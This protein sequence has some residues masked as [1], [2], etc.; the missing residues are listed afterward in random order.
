MLVS[1]TLPRMA[2]NSQYWPEVV[3][4]KELIGKGAIGTLLS[5]RG[6]HHGVHAIQ[7]EG[8]DWARRGPNGEAGKSWRFDKDIMGGGV[9]IDGGAHWIVG[10]PMP[11]PVQYM[12]LEMGS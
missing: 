5:G 3:R 2:E 11:A 7:G 10:S 4:A 9:V 12:Y 6:W 8:S 1:L